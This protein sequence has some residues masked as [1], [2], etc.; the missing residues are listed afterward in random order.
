M[1]L[2]GGRLVS[3]MADDYDDQLSHMINLL[4]PTESRIRAGSGAESVQNLTSG[5]VMRQDHGGYSR[6]VRANLE[7]GSSPCRS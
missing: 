7:R 1:R 4:N 2:G 5:Q 6:H 3:V